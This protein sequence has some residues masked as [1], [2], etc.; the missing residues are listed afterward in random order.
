MVSFVL[1]ICRVICGGVCS[2]RD[3]QTLS[4]VSTH[5][6]DPI[7]QSSGPPT[8]VLTGMMV[9]L[10]ALGGG[11]VVDTGGVKR[12][13]VTLS[14]GHGGCR[15]IDLALDNPGCDFM[16]SVSSLG[17]DIYTIG[18]LTKLGRGQS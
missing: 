5:D 7:P 18:E 13:D 2:L 14:V 6:R 3:D 1:L 8:R 17:D 11:G 9:G 10:Q 16:R 15:D 12:D 4:L